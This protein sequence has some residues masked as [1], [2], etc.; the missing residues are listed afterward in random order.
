MSQ[1]PPASL[2]QV[3]A[4][5]FWQ[6]YSSVRESIPLSGRVALYR[7]GRL[8]AKYVLHVPDLPLDYCF[9]FEKIRFLETLRTIENQQQSEQPIS[10]EKRQQ[11]LQIWENDLLLSLFDGLRVSD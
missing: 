10:N 9:V 2:F 3:E 4:H 8:H 11:L 6:A 5:A 1:E 7:A